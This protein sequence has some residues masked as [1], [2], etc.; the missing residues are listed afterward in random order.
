MYLADCLGI[1]G[2]C[3]LHAMNWIKQLWLVADTSTWKYH[4][5]QLYRV[6]NSTFIAAVHNSNTFMQHPALSGPEVKHC[7]TFYTSKSHIQSSCTLYAAVRRNI[8]LL[9]LFAIKTENT[10]DSVMFLF[11]GESNEGSLKGIFFSSSVQLL[12]R[13]C[14][15]SVCCEILLCTPFGINW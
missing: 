13:S 1:N 9:T 14:F 12:K 6:I 3:R 2:F 4:L 11:P 15:H 8:I 5:Q 10:Y 7:S